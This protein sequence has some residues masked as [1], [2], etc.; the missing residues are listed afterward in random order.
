M[1]NSLSCRALGNKLTNII[2]RIES[3]RKY[4]RPTAATTRTLTTPIT[5]AKGNEAL[6]KILL[7]GG[8]TGVRK[9]LSNGIL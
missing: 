4:R 9:G 2:D 6:C 7:P 8:D 3:S 5:I 1:V